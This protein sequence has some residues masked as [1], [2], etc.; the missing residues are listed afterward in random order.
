MILE[1][2]LKDVIK[3]QDADVG[4]ISEFHI[5]FFYPVFV[6]SIGMIL[7]LLASGACYAKAY[8]INRKDE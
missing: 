1:L 7:L 6:T 4:L 2:H 8:Q 3:A 5:Q